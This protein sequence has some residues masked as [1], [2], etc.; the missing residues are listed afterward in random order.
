[1][2]DCLL[3]IFVKNPELGKVKTRLA[4][5]LG[6]AKALEVYQS[7]LQHTREVVLQ[8]PVRR[9]LLYA[10]EIPDEDAWPKADFDKRL[11]AKDPDLGKRMA[12]AFE[13][14]FAE[15][16]GRVVIIGSDCPEIR[17]RHLI[18]AFG[19]LEKEDFVIGPA[20]DGG[21]YLLG[22]NAY[23]PY[24]FENKT[25]S[26]PTV[27]QDTLCDIQNHGHSLH[28]LPE[29]V[30]LDDQADWQYLQPRYFPNH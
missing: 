23:R 6:D 15:G 9:H 12:Q 4:E 25:W 18:D 20:N 16:Y 21:Y 26:T 13:Q 5:A 14:G 10:S 28:Q 22:M 27:R 17:P 24:V 19:I 2:F 11:Q 3:L 29:L 30:D 7:L 1:M 8:V